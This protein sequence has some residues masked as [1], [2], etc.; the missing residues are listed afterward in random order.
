MDWADDIA[1][2]VHD[3][4]DGVYAGHIALDALSTAEERALLCVQTAELYSTET[5][6]DL[7]VVL[8]DLLTRAPFGLPAYDGSLRAQ[9][10]LKRLTSE[11]IARFV[12]AAIEATRAQA[13]DGPLSRYDADL[14]VPRRVRAECAL[15]KAVAYRYVM[16]TSRAVARNERQRE[17]V[18]ELVAAIAARAP[19]LLDRALQPSW[20]AAGSNAQRLRVVVDQVARLTDVSI[21]A[22]HHRLVGA[23]AG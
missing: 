2:S 16:S 6:D 5:A 7:R 19:A 1:Y 20:E 18:L 22:W 11:L 17:L 8:D 9:V 12:S 10:A 23:R 4:E 21:R 13:G 15:L 3:L 14:T